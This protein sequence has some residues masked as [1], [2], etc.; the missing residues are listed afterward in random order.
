L[1]ISI[2]SLA[3]VVVRRSRLVG[4]IVL[5]IVGII[6]AIAIATLRIS[7][8]RIVVAASISSIVLKCI[9]MYVLGTTIGVNPIGIHGKLTAGNKLLSS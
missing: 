1:T 2:A 9:E 7:I 3:V 4:I 5:V 8:R 6:I